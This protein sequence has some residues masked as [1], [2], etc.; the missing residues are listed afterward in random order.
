MEPIEIKRFFRNIDKNRWDGGQF[1][2]KEPRASSCTEQI[3]NEPKNGSSTEESE[4]AQPLADFPIVDSKDYDIT[5]KTTHY[6]QNNHIIAKPKTKNT[7]AAKN[8]EKAEFY[9]M[10]DLKTLIHK[11]SIDQKR[12]ELKICVKNKQKKIAPEE[13]F[14]GF[15]QNH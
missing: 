10:V 15:R 1:D 7:E 13:V 9:S 8:L 6:V 4:L 3:E 12:Q 14:S 2:F 11:T 5:E